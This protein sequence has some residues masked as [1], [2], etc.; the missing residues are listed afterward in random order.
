MR[1]ADYIFK[2]LA[3]YGVRHVFLVTGGGAM[4]L[5]DG[6]RCEKRITP[7]CCHHEQGCAIAAEGYVRAGG[8]LGAVNITSGPGGTN[9]LTGVIGQWLDSIPVIYISG[10]VKFETTILSCP[11]LKLRQ[12]G[13]Q[14]IN[15]TD[16]VRP[17]TKYAAVVTDPTSIRYELEKA[18][19]HA[20]NGRPGP[21]W[22]D[23]PLNVQGAQIDETAL[24]GFE[25]SCDQ[26]PPEEKQIDEV[27]ALLKK[28]KR[29]LIIAGHGISIAGAADKFRRLLKKNGIPAVT[30]FCS[31]ELL[32]NTDPLFAGRIGT[33]GQRAGNF[34]L[35]NADLVLS[36]GSR[37]NVR[38][39]S[40]DWKNYAEKAI[41]I[42]VDIDPEELKKK[43]F[44]PD[45]PIRTDA[46]SFIEALLDS[47]E[48]LPDYSDWA[49][50][51]RQR[52]TLLPTVTAEQEAWQDKVN[53]YFF[54]RELSRVLPADCNIVAGNGT[55][56]VALFQS[57]ETKVGQ[58]IFWNSGCAS[59]G[60][61]VPAALG[62]AVSSGKM[63]ICLAGDGS[64]M[65]NMQELQTIRHHNL[66]IKIFLLDNDGYGSIKQ[67]QSNFFGKEL[68]GC[69]GPSG[70]SFPDFLKLADAFGFTTCEIS[71]QQDLQQQIRDVLA[72]D[73]CVFCVVRMPGFLQ[74][75]PKLSSKRLPDGTLVS[76]R[77]EDMFPFLERD[78]FNKHMLQG[79]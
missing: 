10:Q 6:L 71:N 65:M 56:C 40:Y 54:M 70:V 30:T 23:V 31:S 24:K 37:N 55:A 72:E 44:V 46:G 49:D 62:A 39:T 64:F 1:V 38:Q 63:T 26:K 67:T 29:P 57:G 42:A 59:M 73:S 16:I 48:P 7:V 4:Y 2:Y 60:Y 25:C 75:S 33:L 11:D 17:V 79:E 5:N 13:D 68:I 12:L 9:T 27:L 19:H 66:P 53:P 47:N 8:K 14:E 22:L 18:L 3:D 69:D 34:V 28:A 41:K 20:L 78:E 74:F 52:R 77:L 15:I 36:I 45:L 32:D 76:A 58:R 61:D 35:Q 50:W 21:V 51:C 43:T